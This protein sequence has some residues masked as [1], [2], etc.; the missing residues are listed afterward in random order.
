[1]K[2]IKKYSGEDGD[3]FV[4]EEGLSVKSEESSGPLTPAQKIE[5]SESTKSSAPKNFKQA[6]AEARGNNEKTF[7][8]QGKKYTT[9]LAAPKPAAKPAEP[10]TSAPPKG[11]SG[12]KKSLMD[13]IPLDAPRTPVKGEKIDSTELGRNINNALNATPGIQAVG[14]LKSAGQAAQKAGSRALSAAADDGITF[15][16]KSGRR[17]VGG[18]DELGGV[19]GRA[20]LANNPKRQLPAPTKQ[21]GGPSK[22]DLMAIGM[23]KGG[24]VSPA[25]KRADGIVVKGKTKGRFV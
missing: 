20:S 18:F 24:K 17:Q 16:G 10:A 21:I 9:E 23:K 2:R 14:R 1:M 4:D 19:S 6:F 25:S 22:S 12:S 11:S 7:E 15:L 3:S 8:W 13:Q 5:F